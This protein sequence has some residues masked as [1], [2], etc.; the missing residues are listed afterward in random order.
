MHMNCGW[1]LQSGLKRCNGDNQNTGIIVAKCTCLCFVPLFYCSHVNHA[2]DST[3][4]GFKLSENALDESHF[5]QFK[6]GITPSFFANFFVFFVFCI[7]VCLPCSCFLLFLRLQILTVQTET[8]IATIKNSTPPGKYFIHFFTCHQ[9][10][11]Q[12]DVGGAARYQLCSFFNIVQKEGRG[13]KPIFKK[14][15]RLV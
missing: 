15:S 3:I 2:F 8:I 12:H 6:F 13:V 11:E 9:S 14:S 7:F 4:S 1:Y 5:W 10:S